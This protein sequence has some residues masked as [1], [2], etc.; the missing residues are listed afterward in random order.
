MS[1]ET[2]E[3]LKHE[4]AELVQKLKTERDE[5]RVQMHLAKAEAQEEFAELEKKWDQ[6][7]TRAS[8]VGDVAAGASKDVGAATRSLGEELKRGYKRV[9]DAIRAAS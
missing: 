4:I 7:H 5:L 1:K 9:R 2:V 6:F 3:N 8:A